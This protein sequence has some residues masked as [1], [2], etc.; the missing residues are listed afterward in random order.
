MNHFV[1]V[2]GKLSRLKIKVRIWSTAVLAAVELFDHV[3]RFVLN[4][5]NSNLYVMS[6][7]DI[8]FL[9]ARP[10]GRSG[11]T[12][13]HKRETNQPSMPMCCT[14]KDAAVKP[15]RRMTEVKDNQTNIQQISPP[16]SK[17]AMSEQVEW[18]ERA[19]QQTSTPSSKSV[20]RSEE[21]E[22][23]QVVQEFTPNGDEEKTWQEI[24]AKMEPPEKP[25][26]K[27]FMC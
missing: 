1:V 15:V 8:S 7:W 4:C 13:S 11:C 22:E 2:E 24:L 5:K 21:E 9:H 16:R 10:F 27:P 6:S 14:P 3:Y 18:N 12:N 25:K 20:P 19:A 17:S 26:P 23:E